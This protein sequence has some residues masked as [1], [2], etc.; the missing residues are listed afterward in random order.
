[1]RTAFYADDF[2]RLKMVP[3]TL[4][5]A[6]T[7]VA[8]IAAEIKCYSGNLASF[9]HSTDLVDQV[10][11][12]TILNC[13]KL[14]TWNIAVSSLGETEIEKIRGALIAACAGDQWA[15]NRIEGQFDKVLRRV[16]VL[17]AIARHP[18]AAKFYTLCEAIEKGRF[19][20]AQWTFA[21]TLAKEAPAEMA[22]AA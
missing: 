2:N 3:A 4:E 19:T 13:F 9:A 16:R 22:H 7:D 17:R 1:M 12:D 18:R 15:R 14:M 11:P 6:L 5:S 21:L 8:D 20:K 10:G